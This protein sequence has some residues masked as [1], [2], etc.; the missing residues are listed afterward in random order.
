MKRKGRKQ[1]DVSACGDVE[2]VHEIQKKNGKFVFAIYRIED[3]R[4]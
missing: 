1:K 3:H 4:L 2:M